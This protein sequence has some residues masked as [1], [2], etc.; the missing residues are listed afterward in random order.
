MIKFDDAVEIVLTHEGG[1]VDHPN[2]PGGETKF[3]ISKRSYPAVDIKNL[4]R[5]Q[6]KA[7]YKRDFWDKVRGDDF[8]I[9]V[10]LCIFD[11]AVNAGVDRAVRILQ[12]T[13]GTVQ[14]GKLGNLTIG[15][16]NTLHRNDLIER[17]T[18]NRILY[19]TS[20]RT[21]KSFGRGWTRRS[22]ETM[23]TALLMRQ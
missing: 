11:F 2:D 20:L 6:A 21:F 12:M 22:I 5:A 17:F 3:G 14:D 9:G 4:T 1:Y 10:G 23:S 13:V 18:A 19:Y 16:A 15:K 8:P 7:I